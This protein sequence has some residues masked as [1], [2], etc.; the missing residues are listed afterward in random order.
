[1]SDSFAER[2]VR[3]IFKDS[4]FSYEGDRYKVTMVEKPQGE[5]K[6]DFYIQARNIEQKNDKIFK[7]SY[8]KPNYSF[9]ENKIRVDRAKEIFGKEWKSIL[10]KD[11][12]KSFSHDDNKIFKKKNPNESLQES[13]LTFPLIDRVK[14]KIVLGFRFEIESVS[15]AGGRLLSAPIKMN[16]A[17]K[18]YWGKG[19]ENKAIKVGGKEILGSGVPDYILVQDPNEIE[20]AQ[21]IFDRLENIQEYSKNNSKMRAT[22]LSQYYRWHDKKEK[23]VTEGFSRMFAVWVEWKVINKKISGRIVFDKPLEKRAGDVISDLQK[24]MVELGIDLSSDSNIDELAKKM[25][26]PDLVR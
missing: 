20:T 5:T 25:D 4:E 11:I 7:I 2:N 8:K 24:C 15:Q 22:F 6:T 21:D 23:W 26:R 17:D 9:V 12:I 3:Q 1:M 16:I 14:K 18:V 19:S 13:F 10:E